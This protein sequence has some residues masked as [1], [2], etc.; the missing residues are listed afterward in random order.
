MLLLVVVRLLLTTSND[1]LIKSITDPTF[2]SAVAASSSSQSSPPPAQMFKQT[3]GGFEDSHP[4][5]YTQDDR[6]K[7]TKRG[8]DSCGDLA[9]CIRPSS[10]RSYSARS[11]GGHKSFAV[12]FVWH[13]AHVRIKARRCKDKLLRPSS[14]PAPR[15]CT[16]ACIERDNTRAQ[17]HGGKPGGSHAKGLITSSS[18][19]AAPERCARRP[20]RKQLL[21]GLLRVR[22][23]TSDLDSNGVIMCFNPV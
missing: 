20:L 2:S 9:A 4:G 12:A 22:T 14:N 18:D 7:G 6:R 5:L 3:R 21:R 19:H 10:M 8:W 16:H 23:V 1:L 17:Q 13:R 11:V 15:T